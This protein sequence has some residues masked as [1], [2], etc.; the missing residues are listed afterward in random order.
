LEVFSMA[1]RSPHTE[2][3]RRDACA[4]VEQL[5]AARVQH[6]VTTAAEELGVNPETLRNW[7]D[8][9]TV[10]PSLSPAPITMA[11]QRDGGGLVLVRLAR[12]ATCSTLLVGVRDGGNLPAYVCPRCAGAPLL[13]A[14]TVHRYAL[15]AVARQ[16]PRLGTWQGLSELPAL[17]AGLKIDNRGH[18][19][20]LTW[21][22]ASRAAPVATVGQR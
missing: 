12:H 1:S 6:A 18:T 17:L 4:R 8:A 22:P 13:R 19:V 5:R 20:A 9:Y 2:Q 10:G 14:D 3:F 11:G 7:L 15:A 21:R 16:A